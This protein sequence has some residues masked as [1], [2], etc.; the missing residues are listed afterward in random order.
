LEILNNNSPAKINRDIT[1]NGILICGQNKISGLQDAV[2]PGIF[3]SVF[4]LAF[5]V[6]G[7]PGLSMPFGM[8]FNLFTAPVYVALLASVVALGVLVFVYRDHFPDDEFEQCE[9]TTRF[10]ESIALRERKT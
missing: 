3:P 5:A 8:H 9:K 10:D 4:Q 2:L 7:Y 1:G 6:L